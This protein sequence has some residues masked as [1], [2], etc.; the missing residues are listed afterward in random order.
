MNKSFLLF[1]LPPLVFFSLKIH[2]VELQGKLGAEAIIFTDEAKYS[3]QK[4]QYLSGVIEP[5]FFHAINDNQEL[6]AKLF[7][8]Y[9][10]DSTSRTHADVRELML[11]HYED[12]WELNLGIGKVF[13]GKTESRHLVDVINQVDWAESL[14]D[15]ERLGQP[16][17]QVKLIKD[18]GVLDLFVLPYFREVDYLSKEGRPRINPVVQNE[19]ALFQNKSKQRHVDIAG[20]W[21]QTFDDL[22]IGISAFVGTQRTP[23]FKPDFSTGELRLTPVYVQTAQIGVDAQ[24]IYEDFLLKAEGLARESHHIDYSKHQSFAGVVGLEYTLVGVFDTV[25]DVGLIVEY[26]HDDWEAITPFQNDLMTGVRFVMNDTQSTELLVGAITDL[27]DRSQFWSLEAS[28]RIGD[29]WK[30]EVLARAVASVDDKNT[31]SAYKQDN[32]FSFRLYYYF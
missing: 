9:D 17:V 11:N 29:N 24:Y 31:I 15:E 10:I 7:Y 32:L 3:P 21:S 28:R 2:A 1:L 8:R 5:E 16:M 18:W 23:L 14:D 30:A 6:K 26:L 13:W 12:E 19:E 4:N 27:E 20:R 22:D 25:Y